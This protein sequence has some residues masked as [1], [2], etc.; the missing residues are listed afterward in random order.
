MSRYF[1]FAKESTY[2][3]PVA[4]ANFA[5]VLNLPIKFVP[6]KE[7]SRTIEG[8]RRLQTAQ[9]TQSQS[10][11]TLVYNPVYDKGLGEILH[12]LL[13]KVTSTELE[14]GVR[15]S[16]VFE[17]LTQITDSVKMPSYTIEKGIDSITAER[18]PGASA[19]RLQVRAN[20]A[21]FVQLSADMFA[22]KP[23]SETLAVGPSFS[24]QNYINAG[25]VVTQTLGAATTK[26]EEFSLD[27]QGGA[28]PVFRPGSKEPDSIDLDEFNITGSFTT[29]F[30]S[31]SDLTDFL[32]DTNKALVYKWDGPA[33]GAS[34][35]SLQLDLPKLSFDEG[36]IEVNEQSRTVQ[37]RN[38]TAIE[39]ASGDI[40]K[41]TLVNNVASY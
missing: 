14:V 30:L 38:F 18:Y 24:S 15:W 37:V 5:R 8:G 41:A 28:I 3:T 23:T 1:G 26:F 13:G 17:P 29:R 40:F 35:Y 25:Q 39:D 34:K 21:S 2:G 27:I 36:D 19:S 4:P 9:E 32:N 6:T 22:K 16:H 12:M 33:L 20:P 31:A 11:G 7:Y 10:E